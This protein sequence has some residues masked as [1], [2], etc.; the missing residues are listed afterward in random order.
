MGAALEEAAR[1]L[2][3]VVEARGAEAVVVLAS[4]HAGNEDLFTQRRF[5]DALGVG[6]SGAAVV[7]GG[8]DA[9]LVKVDKAANAEG[10]RRIGFGDAAD[11]LGRIRSGAAAAALVLGHDLL[12]AQFLGGPDALAAL[13]VLVVLDTHQSALLRVADVL[14]PVRHAAEKHA[15]LTNHA[16]RVQRV[17]PAVEPAFEAWSD[18]EVIEKLGA[19]LG[20][21]GFEGAYEVRA[22]SKALSEALP[23]FAGVHLGTLGDQGRALADAAEGARP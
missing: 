11:V 14:V 8:G 6:A 13:D 23:A 15:T 9:L 22:A 17:Q 3:G 12:D 19:L 20:L 16:G 18:G 5:C 4:P 1:R 7:Q 10:A 2:R 21:D